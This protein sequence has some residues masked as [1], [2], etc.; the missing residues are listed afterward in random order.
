MR[1]VVVGGT[2]ITGPSV[3]RRLVELGHEVRVYHSGEHEADLPPGVEH[4]HHPHTRGLILEFAEELKHPAPDVVL[5]MLLVGEEDS[6]AAMEAWRGVAGRIV[7]ISSGDVYRAWGLLI[8]TEEG[9]L[10]PVPLTEDS[11]LRRNPY[12]YRKEESDPDDPDGLANVY[13]KILVER[14]LMSDPELPGTILRLPMVYGQRDYQHRLYPYVRRMDDG[15]PAIL[16]EEGFAAWR[17]PRGLMENVAEAIVLAVTNGLAAGR[18]YHVSEQ[19]AL[20]EAEWVRLVG[21]A[22]GWHG[23]VVALPAASMPAHLLSLDGEGRTARWEQHA[24]FDTSRI[25]RELGY[26]EPVPLGEA[27]RRAV[28]W[29]RANPPEEGSSSD[30]GGRFDYAAEDAAL[31]GAGHK[32]GQPV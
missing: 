29:E 8:S 3:V 23:E 16:L 12:P 9:P 17:A 18:T 6:R 31:A 4:V 7:G 5:H 2:G 27:L 13:D 21:E 15:R 32:R 24:H 25:R 28:E 11:P 14:T 10:E 30:P 22:A 20:T 26:T 1:V 19:D